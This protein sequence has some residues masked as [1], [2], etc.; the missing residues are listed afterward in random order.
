M[1]DPTLQFEGVTLCSMVRIL[2][3][4]NKTWKESHQAKKVKYIS[5]FFPES[6][7]NVKFWKMHENIFF[8]HVVKVSV[9]TMIYNDFSAMF[10]ITLLPLYQ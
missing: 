7:T 4:F 8:K 3:L 6:S 9:S 2:L 5:K 1:G 10:G